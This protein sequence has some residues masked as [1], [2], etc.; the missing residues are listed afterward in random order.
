VAETL[1]HLTVAS[2]VL[3][4]ERA[5]QKQYYFGGKQEEPKKCNIDR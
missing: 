5:E 1:Q 4:W 2:G 3:N